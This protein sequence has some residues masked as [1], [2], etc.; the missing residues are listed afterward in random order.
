[1][2]PRIT[3]DDLLVRTLTMIIRI[4]VSC[5]HHVE[6]LCNYPGWNLEEFPKEAHMQAIRDSGMTTK[7]MTPKLYA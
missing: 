7:C 2:K 4:E 6:E 5:W 1:M 3:C